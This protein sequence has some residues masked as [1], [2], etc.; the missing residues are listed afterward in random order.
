MTTFFKIYHDI[1]TRHKTIISH[2]SVASFHD[3]TASHNVMRCHDT[4]TRRDM[5]TSHDMTTIVVLTLTVPEIFCTF[6]GV[7]LLCARAGDP[8]ERSFM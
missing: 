7:L 4:R 8:S 2:D 6:V 5:M 1:M 3:T